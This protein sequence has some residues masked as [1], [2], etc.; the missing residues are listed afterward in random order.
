MPSP[1]SY[2]GGRYLKVD[3]EI[4]FCNSGDRGG[5]TSNTVMVDSDGDGEKDCFNPVTTTT[6]TTIPEDDTSRPERTDYGA[7]HST[8]RTTI[9][10]GLMSAPGYDQL[11]IVQDL[12]TT[13]DP[14]ASPACTSPAP[15]ELA[16]LEATLAAQTGRSL[17]SRP[18]AAT[19]RRQRK[20][21]DDEVSSVLTAAPT[22]RRSC[23]TAR[24]PPPRI[25]LH[26]RRSR[27]TSPIAR[28]PWRT[29][30]SN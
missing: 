16:E 28:T 4:D 11:L 18:N 21:I 22:S 26:Y 20:R 10:G 5:S 12:D 6:E 27:S 24:S 7:T 14:A 9:L 29:T 25:S 8:H 2:G 13:L 1:E 15:L 3:G 30:S 17:R 19:S 23:T